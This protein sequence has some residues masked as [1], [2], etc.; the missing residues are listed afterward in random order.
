MLDGDLF[1]T[2]C[3]AVTTHKGSTKVPPQNW[4]PFLYLNIACH[5][6]PLIEASCPPTIRVAGREPQLPE[7]KNTILRVMVSLQLESDMFCGRNSQTTNDKQYAD[8]YSA[9]SSEWNFSGQ[10][11]TIT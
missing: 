9:K 10:S 4:P 6:Q 1:L 5:D 11:V 2:Q 7:K 8:F 3:A